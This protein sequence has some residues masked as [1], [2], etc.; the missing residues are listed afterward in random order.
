M[1]AIEV[2]MSHGVKEDK[3]IFLNLVRP[4]SGQGR[5]VTNDSDCL[6]RRFEYRLLPL[7]CHTSGELLYL[8]ARLHNV[9]S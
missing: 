3:I 7:S 9:F 6:P 2:L 1:K 8:S 5:T 4:L